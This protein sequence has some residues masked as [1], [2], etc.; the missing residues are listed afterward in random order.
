MTPSISIFVVNYNTCSLLELCL[1]SIFE[2]KGDISV[3]VFVADNGSTDGTPEMIESKFPQVLLTRNS[4]NVGYVRAVN[5]LLPLADGEYFLFL[6]P[7]VQIP[8][9]TLNRFVEFLESRSE[10]GIAGGNLYYPDGSPNPTEV[11]FPNFKN[12]LLCFALRLF[13]KLPGGRELVGNHNPVEWSRK[14]TSQVNWVWNACMMVRSEVFEAVGYFDD[15]FFVW[16]ADWDLC[17]RAVDAGWMVYYLHSARAIHYERQSFSKEDIIND[18]IRYKVDGWHSA[19]KQIKDRHVFLKKYNS[20]SSFFGIKMIHIVENA[21][22][23]WLILGNL[24]LGKTTSKDAS[25]QLKACLQTIQGIQK[26]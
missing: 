12:E 20:R 3:E 2:T 22:R 5:P 21:L 16:Y 1:R 17:K 9:N 13:R 14:S 24:L 8:K 26:T 18:E 19:P 23:L 7:D 6:H 25:F 4:Q 10:A 15:E 11:L